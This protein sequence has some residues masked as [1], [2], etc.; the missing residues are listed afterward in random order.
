MEGIR[1]TPEADKTLKLWVK[2]QLAARKRVAGGHGKN[3]KSFEFKE[4]LAATGRVIS[5]QCSRLKAAPQMGL[6]TG[7]KRG[8]IRIRFKTTDL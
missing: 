4:Q 8:E 5:P 1:Q 3:Q 2:E 6:K 7:F